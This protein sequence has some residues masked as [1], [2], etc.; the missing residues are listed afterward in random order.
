MTPL[1]LPALT[2][3][4]L[5]IAPREEHPRYLSTVSL[6]LLPPHLASPAVG[7]LVG[8]AGFANVFCGVAA[9]TFAGGCLT[10]WLA[11]PRTGR[12]RKD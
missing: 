12:A 8:K 7:W 1:L 2:N 9:L 6:G 5:E 10:F 4:T 11:E 3:Y